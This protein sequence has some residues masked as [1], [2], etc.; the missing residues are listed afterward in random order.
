MPGCCACATTGRHRT[1]EQSDELAAFQLIELHL[2]PHQRGLYR[3][4]SN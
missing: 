1:A 3:I 2:I 4:M